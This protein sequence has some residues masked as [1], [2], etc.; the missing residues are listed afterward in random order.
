LSQLNLDSVFVLGTGRPLQAAVPVDS[1]SEQTES[2]LVTITGFQIVNPAQWT[3][4]TG[5]GFNVQV[6]N[7]IRTIDLRI[8]NDCDLFNQAV[9][10][11]QIISI[12]GMGGQFDSS[13]PRNAGYQL[14]PR[15][16]SDIVLNTSVASE[17]R[18]NPISFFPNPTSG[19]VRMLY[20]EDLS[21]SRINFHLFNAQGQLVME[22][23]GTPS[24]ISSLLSHQLQTSPAGYFNATFQVGKDFYRTTVVK[25]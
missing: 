4:G 5:T 8:D 2:N 9:P 15:R 21:N 3:T 11:N 12:T 17:N 19:N 18:K 7:G 22:K 20:P 10:S 13:I 1:L 25:N 6:S 16:A 14:L 24:E 23:A